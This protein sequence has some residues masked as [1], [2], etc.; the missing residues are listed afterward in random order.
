MAVNNQ[1]C[2]IE[3]K[4]GDIAT[5]AAKAFY[6]NLEKHY[7]TVGIHREEG[8][9]QVGNNGYTLI[10]N[11]CNQEFGNTQTVEKTRRFKSPY[12]G[13]WFYI[14]KGTQ[15]NIPPR[16]FIR[17]F[18]SNKIKKELTGVF[19]NQINANIKKENTYQI[20]DAVG[21][22]GQLKQKERIISNSIKPKNAKMTKVYKGSNTPMYLT[23]EIF[24][25]IKHEVH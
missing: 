3:Y 8:A 17:I 4:K 10:K 11:A 24:S 2:T 13:K 9:K 5:K 15:L 16:L 12:T 22:W 20:Y 7:V 6:K 14:K 18:N 19:K 23:G 25:A 1:V 21:L